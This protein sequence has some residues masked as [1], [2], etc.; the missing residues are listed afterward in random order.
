MKIKIMYIEHKINAYTNVK[1]T[2]KGLCLSSS[3]NSSACST[4]KS[5]EPSIKHSL[6][7]SDMCLEKR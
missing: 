5:K 4:S 3:H 7:T 6:G 2:L 1:E